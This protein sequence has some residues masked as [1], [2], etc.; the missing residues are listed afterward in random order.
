MR[1]D[2]RHGPLFFLRLLGRSHDVTIS[3]KTIVAP[4][5]DHRSEDVGGLAPL[6]LDCEG[7]SACEAQT[8]MLS[9]RG[10]HALKS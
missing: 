8:F 2:P 7:E 3:H 5:V 4:N 10:S 6:A 1:K 9:M